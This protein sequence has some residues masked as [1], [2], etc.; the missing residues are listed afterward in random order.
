MHTCIII[1]DDQINRVFLSHLIKNELKDLMVLASF[2][3]VENAIASFDELCP[4]LVFLDI[5]L[6]GKSGIDFLTEVDLSNTEVIVVTGHVEYAIKALKMDVID[7]L[8]KPFSKEDVF[9]AYLKFKQK[10]EIRHRLKRYESLL[11][12]LDLGKKQN[13]KIGVAQQD[14]IVFLDVH[15]ITRCEA[16]SNY[17]NVFLSNGKKVVATKTLRQFEELLIPYGFIRVHR[18]HLVNPGFITKLNKGD[19]L[20]VVMIDGAV[21][22]VANS[23]KAHLVDHFVKI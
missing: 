22:D 2:D 19:T 10:F 14:A 5:E 12:N 20:Q 18:S 11:N 9:K 3:S 16:S 15:D 6:P 21:V 23:H 17:T 4:D 1:E 8:V 13:F 7:Y